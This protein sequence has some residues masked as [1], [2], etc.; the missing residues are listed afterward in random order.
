MRAAVSSA[1]QQLQRFAASFHSL[2]SQ[3]K[4]TFYSVLTADVRFT[5]KKLDSEWSINLGMLNTATPKLKSE[6]ANAA[7]SPFKN[8]NNTSVGM[9]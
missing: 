6:L 8:L 5:F 3:R 1:S 2:H 7:T 4:M 9:I